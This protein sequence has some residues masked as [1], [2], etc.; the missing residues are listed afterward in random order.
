MS[1]SPFRTTSGPFVEVPAPVTSSSHSDARKELEDV[2]FDADIHEFPAP[3]QQESAREPEARRVGRQGWFNR[4]FSGRSERRLREEMLEAELRDLRASYAGLLHS[5]EDLREQVELDKES[6]ESVT[7]ALSPFP[8]AVA[9]IED[10]QT[11]QEEAGEILGSIRERLAT[12]SSREESLLS[13]MDSIHGGFGKLQTEM[14]SVNLGVGK[15]TK[16]VSGI[17]EGQA[18]ASAHLGRFSEK[19]ELRFKE[20]ARS[21]QANAERV[22]QSGDEVLQVLRQV[23][24]NSQRGLWI[25][26]TLLAVLFIGLICFAAKLSQFTSEAVVE[27]EGLPALEAV[28]TPMDDSLVATDPVAQVSEDDFEF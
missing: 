7:K 23:E 18:E 13:S 10:I 2:P 22:E 6:R 26:A 12:T 4:L 9:G 21:A 11:R 14:G 25:F 5:T 16:A 3:D 24:R 8:S 19:I 20:A 1:V 15:M 28:A 27:P 17:A